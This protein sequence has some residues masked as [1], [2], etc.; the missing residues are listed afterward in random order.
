MFASPVS[1]HICI[2]PDPGS[3]PGPSDP[4]SRALPTRA[5]GLLLSNQCICSSSCSARGLHPFIASPTAALSPRTC[6]SADTHTAGQQL[7]TVTT[8]GINTDRTLATPRWMCWQSEHNRSRKP[9]ITRRIRTVVERVSCS[10]KSAHTHTASMHQQHSAI[11]TF[12]VDQKQVREQEER[13]NRRCSQ[14]TQQCNS[15]VP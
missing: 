14:L 4:K 1:R 5:R 13:A 9:H 15:V 12:P 2:C 3:N 7:T 10:A 6:I 8:H 11:G